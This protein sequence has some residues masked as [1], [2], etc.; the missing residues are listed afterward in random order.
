M[1]YLSGKITNED[2]AIQEYNLE[3]F[4]RKAEE[5]R[6]RNIQVFNPADLETPGYTWEDY[7]ARDLLWITQHKP[8]L[9]MM[10]GWEESRG[11]RLEHAL[12]TLMGLEITY[13]ADL[14][15]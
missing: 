12:G 8:V 13:E 11:A 3:V 14:G 15:L 4:N 7:L 10:R 1:I 9:Y 5:F 6:E 2:P